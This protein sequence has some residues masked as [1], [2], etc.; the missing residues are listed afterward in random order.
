GGTV[1][2]GLTDGPYSIRVRDANAVNCFITLADVIIDPLPVA[3]TLSSAVDY[4]C[5]G[6]GNITITPLD[7]T[8]TYSID[9]GTPQTSNVF[10]NIT[11]GNHTVTVNYGSECTTDI[12]VNVAAGR[13]FNATITNPVNISCFGGNDGSF[14][15]NA[16][17]FGA[18]GF[19]YSLDGG[20]TFVGPFTTSQTVPGLVADTHSV[21]V[22]DVDEPTA[23]S[24][25]LNQQLTE[26]AVL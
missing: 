6:S 14:V 7:A 8:Y 4:N 19:E 26:P 3:P 15:I 9:G 1:F 17:N 11:P 22:R 16:T 23:C 12:V 13:A 24:V 18:G 2:T 10:T 20:I 25:I 5:D 21:E